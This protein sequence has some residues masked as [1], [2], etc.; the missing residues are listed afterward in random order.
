MLIIHRAQLKI[1]E[2]C[3]AEDNELWTICRSKLKTLVL[4][5]AEMNQS[6]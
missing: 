4:Y 2:Y 3:N 5:E 6:E 1:I